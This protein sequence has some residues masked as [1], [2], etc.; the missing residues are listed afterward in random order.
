LTANAFVLRQLPCLRV[1][2]VTETYSPE[3]NSVAMTLGRLVGALLRRGQLVQLI[4]PRQAASDKATQG[5]Q[6]QAA[7][8]PGIPI[9]RYDA[10][11]KIGLPG[12]A[13]TPDYGR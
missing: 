10:L 4:R 12:Q 8:K 11:K 9:P 5:E 6:F 2:V 1:A 13:W 3:V 7:L